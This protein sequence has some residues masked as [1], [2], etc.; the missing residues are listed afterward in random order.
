MSWLLKTLLKPGRLKIHAGGN[1]RVFIRNV[2][3]ESHN[4]SVAALELPRPGQQQ[5]LIKENVRVLLMSNAVN[6]LTRRVE[7]TLRR[8]KV[9]CNTDS[10]KDSQ[11]MM[12]DVK[13]FRPDIVICPFLK[14]KIPESLYKNYTCL[15]MH[16]GIA[17]D[18]G[19]SSLDWAILENEREWGVTVLQANDEMDGG[20]IWSTD[21]FEVPQGSIKTSLYNG[22]VSD[23][24]V[25]CIVD[26]LS[27]YCQGFYPIPQSS[28]PHI[29]GITRRNM[30]KAD[31]RIDWTVSAEEISARVRMSDTVPGAIA[32]FEQLGL[33]NEYRL[34]DA[35]VETGCHSE[36]IRDLM[37]KSEPGQMIGQRY[38]SVLVKAGD[39]NAVWIGQMKK[40]T[41]DLALKVPSMDLLKTYA[42]LK[43]P[44]LDQEPSCYDDIRVISTGPICYV[45]FDFYNGA[46]DT[47]QAARLE[48]T[49]QNLDE[50]P[51]IKVVVLMGGDRFFST[52]I[53]LCVIE[54][55][56]FKQ[57]EARANI[58][59]INN[60]IRSVVKMKNK[61]TVAVLQG[62]A[63]AG[64][65]MFAIACDVVVSHPGVLLTPSYKAMNLHG[66]EYW[67]Y[68]LPQRVGEETARR[69]VKDTTPISATTAQSIGLLDHV[70]YTG[71]ESFKQEVQEFIKQF[72]MDG[73]FDDIIRKK[74]VQRDTYWFRL[75]EKHRS[76][77]LERMK[78]DFRSTKFLT[79]M[80]KFVYKLQ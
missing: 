63:G 53:H 2:T 37:I 28:N 7:E 39:N 76:Y 68:F 67:T 20:D 40:E 73:K 44:T 8:Y 9:I 26:A 11:S 1:M 19:A 51:E 80:R 59:G 56:G 46:M 77:E 49:L 65:A 21:T 25:N 62:N 33:Q 24:A 70:L 64:G 16:P 17:G 43:L 35:H 14:S 22:S 5:V 23:A 78:E 34:F 4:R 58:C 10:V 31:R 18:H 42:K 6:T 41:K 52:G 50:V 72:H 38:N 30:K 47:R 12:D 55:S 71:K 54:N 45:H 75:I 61:A 48:K 69:L 32:K 36:Y 29:K 79:S 3:K 13:M 60:V 27:R 66:S 74:Q 57:T 15:I